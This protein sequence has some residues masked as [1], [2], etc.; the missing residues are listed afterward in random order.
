NKGLTASAEAS[1]LYL[2]GQ[3]LL[4]KRTAESIQQAREFFERAVAKDGDFGLG[5]A[6]IA[7]AYILLGEYGVLPVEEAVNRAWPE[8]SAA[9]QLDDKLAEGY[10]SRAILLADFH[11][12]WDAAEMDYRKAINLNPNNARA[13]HWFALHLAQLGRTD[14]ALEEIA[15]AERHDPLAPII[16][17]A[18]ARILLTGHRFEEAAAQSHKALE[19]ESNFAPAFSVLAQ[20]LVF[21][22]RYEDGIAAAK[23]YVNLAGGGDQELLELAYAEAAAGKA[24]DAQKLVTEVQQRGENFSPYDMAAIC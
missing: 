5:H 9:L 24:T 7:E 20:A 6:G 12:K 16:S 15:I 11:W 22:R 1:E 14:E 18:R 10:L 8:V 4:S 17:A 21:Q 19:L 2:R 23:K 3:Y 13:H